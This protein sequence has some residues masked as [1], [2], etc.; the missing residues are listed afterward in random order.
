MFR[1]ENTE[2]W[3]FEKKIP[4]KVCDA[5]MDIGDALTPQQGVVFEG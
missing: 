1:L 3:V 5:I 2:Y 4:E